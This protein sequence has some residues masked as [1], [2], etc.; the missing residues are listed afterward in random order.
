MNGHRFGQGSSANAGFDK[1]EAGGTSRCS[2]AKPALTAG[3]ED[4]SKEARPCLWSRW[5]WVCAMP[6]RPPAPRPKRVFCWWKKHRYQ[7]S[8]SPNPVLHLS[9][10]RNIVPSL[11]RSLP[12]VKAG[13]FPASADFLQIEVNPIL[14]AKDD[15]RYFAGRLGGVG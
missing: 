1:E 9:P 2:Q 10:Q 8:P 12:P 3:Q 11:A 4:T 15:L 7:E 14:G 6:S 5:Q 13:Y